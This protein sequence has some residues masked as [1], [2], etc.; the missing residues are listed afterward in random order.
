MK[1]IDLDSALVEQ[2]NPEAC[3]GLQICASPVKF[4]KSGIMECNMPVLNE[5]ETQL[6]RDAKLVSTFWTTFRK[7]L[8]AFE[9]RL[10]CYEMRRLFPWTPTIYHHG[11]GSL[12]CCSEVIEYITVC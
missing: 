2:S 10:V 4:G 6:L 3:E 5:M 11:V 9:R 7:G 8:E 12:V 1:P